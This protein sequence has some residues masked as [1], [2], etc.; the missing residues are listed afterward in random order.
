MAARGTTAC[1]TLQRIQT[2]AQF[3]P[4][5]VTHQK[6]NFLSRLTIAS[7]RSIEQRRMRN[8]VKCGLIRY[9]TPRGYIS[10]TA[11]NSLHL[12]CYTRKRI[13]WWRTLWRAGRC[14]VRRVTAAI[15]VGASAPTK[16]N[17]RAVRLLHPDGFDR[18]AFHPAGG[19]FYLRREARSLRPDCSYRDAC[20]ALFYSLFSIF[21]FFRRRARV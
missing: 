3:T 15:L 7:K 11:R 4:I 1:K 8:S 9:R 16:V 21:W 14:G 17:R 13:R 18:D 20:L 12:K 19:A 6:V 5:S 10:Q 2:Y